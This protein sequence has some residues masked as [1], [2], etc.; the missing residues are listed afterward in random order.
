MDVYVQYALVALLTIVLLYTGVRLWPKAEAQIDR[1]LDNVGLAVFN[2]ELAR[3]SG[4]DQQILSLQTARAAAVAQF[5]AH[6]AA[7]AALVIT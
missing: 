2:A 5:K 4:Y 6:Q 3:I 1:G 7:V